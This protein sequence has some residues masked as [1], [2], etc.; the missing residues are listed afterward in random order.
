[1]LVANFLLLGYAF[2]ANTITQIWFNA[3]TCT[4][5]PSV[6]NIIPETADNKCSSESCFCS[7][8]ICGSYSSCNTESISKIGATAFG[9]KNYASIS[10]YNDTTC[11]TSYGP[12]LYLVD[13]CISYGNSSLFVSAAQG[14]NNYDTKNC[15]GKPSDSFAANVCIVVGSLSKKASIIN[16][17]SAALGSFASTN[18]FFVLALSI[19]G[20]VLV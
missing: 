15:T 20:I 14:V 19:A 8:G 9:N 1:M 16:P 18:I 2:A 4:G 12:S 7:G 3:T 6:V 11:T 17:T 5:A 13:T 10:F